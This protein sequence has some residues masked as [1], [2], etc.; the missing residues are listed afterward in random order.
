MVVL[1]AGMAG[2]KRSGWIFSLATLLPVLLLV[3][4]ALL[5][6]LWGWLALMYL[7]PFT[8][9]LDWLMPVATDKSAPARDFPLADRLSVILAVSHFVLLIVAVWALSG[10][11]G[12]S[13][14]DTVVVFLAYGLFF[15]QI[16]NPNAHELIHR[17]D[18]RL[19]D[20][21]KWV[22]IT[23]L[24]GHHTSAHP[25]IHHRF[26]AS[27][28]DPNSAPLGESFYAFAPRA[29]FGSFRAGHEI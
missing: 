1:L 20:L 8:M 6:G 16:S 18:R 14:L 19:F 28:H 27:I 15:G 9:V 12:L 23:L 3:L 26:V 29:W 21:G 25:R 7:S 24:F 22:Y 11:A 17:T 10:H 13:Y 5:G 2:M 4:A